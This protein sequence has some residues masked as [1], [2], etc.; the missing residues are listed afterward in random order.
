[1]FDIGLGEMALIMAIALVAIGPK[2]LPEVARTVAK[3]V[4]EVRKMLAGVSE[5]LADTSQ[6]TN[7][8]MSDLGDEVMR[9][10]PAEGSHSV[11]SS[12][13]VN[14]NSAF[15]PS[16]GEPIQE[17]VLDSKKES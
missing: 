15:D 17:P 7:K 9:V 6:A 3:F 12:S 5:T 14:P 10:K 2:Q 13:A 8:V 11:N 1:M 16:S 4:G